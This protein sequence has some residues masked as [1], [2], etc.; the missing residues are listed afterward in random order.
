[1]INNINDE[2]YYHINTGQ[3]LQIGDILEIGKRFNNFYYEIY[4]IEHLEDGKD[5]NQYLIDMKKE[6]NLVLNNDTANLVF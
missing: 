4:N 5:A 6:R 3:N 1:M 2:I